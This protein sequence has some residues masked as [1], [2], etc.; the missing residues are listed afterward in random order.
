MKKIKTNKG[1]ALII[2]L[3]IMG[4]LMTLALGLSNLVIRE[5][6]ITTDIVNSGKAYFA[7][8]AGIESALLDLHQNLPGYE[9]KEIITDGKFDVGG[10][11]YQAGISED[12]ELE[13]DYQI[14]NRTHTI[15]HIDTEIIDPAIVNANKSRTFNVL[16][17]N[18]SVTIPLFV[19]DENGETIDISDF[20]VEYYIAEDAISPSWLIKGA[21]EDI[22]MLRWKITG[23]KELGASPG[24]G[25]NAPLKLLT[26]SIGDYLPTISGSNENQRT[27]FGTQE[28]LVSRVFNGINYDAECLEATHGRIYYF[29]RE[30]YTFD[31]RPK[32]GGEFEYVTVPH[33]EGVNPMTIGRFLENHSHNYLTLTNIFNPSMIRGLSDFEKRQNARIY[34]RIV[35]PNENEY[36]IR[37]FAKI[38]SVGYV[39]RLRKRIEALIRPDKFMPVF[40]FSLYRTEVE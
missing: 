24:S 29:A 25:P 34:Y 11:T 19:S 20:R 23:I 8:E 32:G 9:A 40:N 13:Y 22:D 12:A 28:S 10:Q 5:V 17:L 36:T 38:T 7:A 14:E 15:P 4:I 27:C 1:S 16:R 26:E 18:E 33:L 31:I 30:A 35:I 39:R 6:S 3:L 2:A 37:E 21:Q